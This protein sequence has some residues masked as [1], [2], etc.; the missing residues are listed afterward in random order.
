MTEWLLYNKI[1]TILLEEKKDRPFMDV[2]EEEKPL[3]ININSCLESGDTET[4]KFNLKELSSVVIAKHRINKRN[5]K[6]NR[7]SVPLAIIGLALTIIF[8]IYSMWDNH[9]EVVKPTQ[10]PIITQPSE[11]IEQTAEYSPR[12]IDFILF[13]D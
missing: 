3:M 12:A 2:P 6:V 4:A 5:E 1:K 7:W 11:I 9:T 13:Y 8:G 10:Q